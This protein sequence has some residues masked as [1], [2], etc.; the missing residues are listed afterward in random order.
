V[1]EVHYEGSRGTSALGQHDERK[2]QEGSHDAEHEAGAAEAD[3]LRERREDEA[4]PPT[5]LA[6]LSHGMTIANGLLI[7]WYGFPLM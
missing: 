2:V 1:H 4:S 7:V 3:V 6:C 5:F